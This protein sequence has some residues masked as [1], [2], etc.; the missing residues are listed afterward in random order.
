MN[1]DGAGLGAVFSGDRFNDPGV[2]Q[3]LFN[4][5][6]NY[7]FDNGLGVRFGVQVTGPISTTQSGYINVAA[8]DLGGFLPL[9]PQSIAQ[10]ANAAGNAYYQSPVIPWQYTMN[11]SVFYEW[12][13]YTVTFSVYNLTDRLNWQSSP[14]F[15]GNDFL[16][17]NDPRTFEVRLQAKF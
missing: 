15:Y 1:I 7:K 3:H 12:K 11:A 6:G 17:R 9:V 8:S 10:T 2:P 5:L 4:F 13:N 14:P 16:V